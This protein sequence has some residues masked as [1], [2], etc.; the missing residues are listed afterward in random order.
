MTQPPDIECPYC[1]AGIEICHDDGF[2]YKEDQPH[3][4]ECGECEKK[5]VFHTSISFDYEA[6]KA[7]CLNG[8]PHD[9]RDS[10]NVFSS[11]GETI[12]TSC[13]TC[14]FEARGD[15]IAAA[16]AEAA[17]IRARGENK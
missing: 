17:A 14:G 3:E 6:S 11:A 16:H 13:R 7:D 10:R 15:G 5:F 8:G 1:N 4:Y 12:A 9:L 2:G